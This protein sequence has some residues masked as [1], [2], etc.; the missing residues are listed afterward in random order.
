M[1]PTLGACI[2][3]YINE[4]INLQIKHAYKTCPRNQHTAPRGK[5]HAWISGQVISL[6]EPCFRWFDKY[7]ISKYSHCTND[8]LL[9][10]YAYVMNL[11]TS[12]LAWNTYI[13]YIFLLQEMS[14]LR[15]TW[16]LLYSTQNNTLT[17]IYAF[18]FYLLFVPYSAGPYITV[19]H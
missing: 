6:K 9:I 2:V 1:C 3:I 7:Q 10:D 11:C 4:N 5:N 13:K 18:A 15:T 19:F 14:I 17:F 12:G 16:I 8:L